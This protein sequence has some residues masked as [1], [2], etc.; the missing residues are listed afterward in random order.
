MAQLSEHRF[1]VKYDVNGGTYLQITDFRNNQRVDRPTPSKLPPPPTNVHSQPKTPLQ[2][3]DSIMPGRV[4]T[5]DRDWLYD[6][7]DTYGE[8]AT[9]EAL[10]ECKRR[11]SEVRS[12][13]KFVEAVAARIKN[14]GNGRHTAGSHM[15][16]EEL[17]MLERARRRTRELREQG[18]L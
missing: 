6:V 2:L 11:G 5:V 13:R 15:S 12:V 9:A 3:L 17:E 4:S 10:R 7:I 18:L 1:V 8:Q 16:Q 14:E